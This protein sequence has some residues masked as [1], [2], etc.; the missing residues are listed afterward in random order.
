[1]T[2][3][4]L[5]L[6]A[7]LILVGS[8]GVW[9]WT[10][11]IS[12]TQLDL[13]P[14]LS[15]DDFWRLSASFSEPDGFF[16]SENLVSNETT[17]QDV[18]PE[19]QATVAPG[20]VYVGVGP[21]QNFTYIAALRPRIVF[22]P[23]IRRGNMMLHL[24]YKALFEQ[25][26][27]RA[28]FLS[29]LFSRPMPDGLATTSPPAELFAAYDAIRPDRALFDRTLAAIT[30]RLT[31]EHG[32]PLNEQDL[33]GIEYVFSHF[34]IEGPELSY[35]SLGGARRRYPTYG[36]LQVAT[37]AEGVNH[38]YLATE[39]NFRFVKTMHHNN[40]IVPV[41]GDFG[42]PKTLRRIADYARER[43]A[44][45]TTFYTS[46]VEQYLFQ[47]SS[48]PA[49]AQNVM[50]MPLDETST[51]IRSC[52]NQCSSRSGSRSVTLLDSIPGLMKDFQDGR[53][54][55]YWAVLNHSR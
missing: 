52:F 48:W 39:P 18:I 36:E 15:D 19:L 3:R 17:F 55:S 46:N 54:G 31:E 51:F 21:D 33:A 25:S 42:G 37:D 24:M 40:L 27:T 41:V 29:K 11:N 14:R 7:P 50:T 49:F 20:G 12:A 35:S 45:V 28:E 26:E 16:R 5:W 43:R 9:V 44:R 47:D 38:S 34:Y 1:V 22:I 32:F 8:L 30:T 4:H 10:Q 53:I 6:F 2:R 23:D 13:P